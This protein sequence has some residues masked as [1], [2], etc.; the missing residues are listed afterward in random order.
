MVSQGN[1]VY[2]RPCIPSGSWFTA[3]TFSFEYVSKSH[4][5][6]S[7]RLALMM[8]GLAMTAQTLNCVRLCCGETN[9]AVFWPDP[10]SMSGS[11]KCPDQRSR[12]APRS[13][14][15]LC[16]YA[17]S[18]QLLQLSSTCWPAQIPLARTMRSTRRPGRP[19][20]VLWHSTRPAFSRTLQRRRFLFEVA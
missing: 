6:I 4:S 11:L 13:F 10:T 1:T 14:G 15:C 19:L 8:R 5:V 18:H 2:G 7:V 16:K 3:I 17:T 12:P 20:C 9:T